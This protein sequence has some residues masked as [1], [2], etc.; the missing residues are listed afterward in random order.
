ME[1]RDPSER[2]LPNLPIPR[3]GHADEIAAT[4]AFLCSDGSGYTTGSTFL[5]DGGMA[6]IAPAH[7]NVEG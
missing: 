1:G 7:G 5:V 2:R 3:P 4:I 6:L